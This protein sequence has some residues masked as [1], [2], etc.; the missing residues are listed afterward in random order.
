MSDY[1]KTVI[2]KICCKDKDITEVY[3][4]HSTNLS[5]RK[6]KHKSGCYNENDTV[7]YTYV[8]EFIRDNGGQ[9]NWELIKLYD[10]PCLSHKEASIEEKNCCKKIGPELNLQNPYRTLE[11]KK[12]QELFLTKEW[13]KNNSEKI[14]EYQKEHSQ[15]PETKQ[16]VKEW[17]N[18]NKDKLKSY[19]QKYLESEK[20][21]KTTK[22]YNEKTREKQK[23]YSKKHYIE[24]SKIKVNCPHCDLL[25]CK[26]S[27]SNHIKKSCKEFKKQL[28]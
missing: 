4:G 1:S 22:E 7:Y 5:S 10:F 9:D 11:E 14:K 19:R 21:M 3:V 23:E 12:E 13:R 24:N 26:G 8:Y 28:Y 20:G 15:K 16:I 17:K 18:K 25:L 6:Y 2:Y 27:L